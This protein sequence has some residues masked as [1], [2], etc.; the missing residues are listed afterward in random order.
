[1]PNSIERRA[2]TKVVKNTFFEERNFLGITAKKSEQ[3]HLRADRTFQ[4]PHGII[5]DNAV[6]LANGAEQVFPEH[7]E[8]FT[9]SGGLSWH[10]VRAGGDDEILPLLGAFSHFKQSSD[11]LSSDELERLDD[12]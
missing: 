5:V 10:V 11:G 6:E 1:M 2:H 9:K 8:A 3:I 4:A 7:G 12:L